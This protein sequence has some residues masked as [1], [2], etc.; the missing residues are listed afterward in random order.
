MLLWLT[1]ALLW[2]TTC[3]AQRKSGWV[4][5]L[6]PIPLVVWALPW[7]RTNSSLRTVPLA[8]RGCIQFW[9]EIACMSPCGLFS[10]PACFFHHLENYKLG[11]DLYFSSTPDY[12]NDIT[13][14]RVSI[15]DSDVIK[16]IQL[17]YGSSWRGSHGV[18]GGKTQEFLLRPREHIIGVFGAHK[19]Y[20]RHL[21]IYTNQGRLAEF[22][23][24]VGSRFSALPGQ[25]E[26]VLVGI[27][28][29][30]N[31]LGITSIGFQWEVP[32][33]G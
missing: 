19:R 29:L 8:W 31:P 20:L 16:S 24:A 28:G 22:G 23:Q 10:L 5:P 25:T 12:E 1:L 30:Y 27:F 18:R 32:R 13:G 11:E 26:M 7:S 14:I 6:Q 2:S 33:V 15:G 21:V 17:R 9:A 4:S 3:W